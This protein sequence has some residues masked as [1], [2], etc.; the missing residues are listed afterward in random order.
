[1]WDRITLICYVWTIYILYKVKDNIF[2]FDKKNENIILFEHFN[3][4][5]M[6]VV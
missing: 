1:M 4:V 3:Y 5:Q 6:N 2:S